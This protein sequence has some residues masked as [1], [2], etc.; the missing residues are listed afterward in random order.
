MFSLPAGLHYRV[1]AVADQRGISMAAYI[2]ETLE[3]ALDIAAVHKIP[4]ARAAYTAVEERPKEVADMKRIVVS[5][6]NDLHERLRVMGASRGI[7]MA[8]FVRD[9]L[10]ER[11]TQARPKPRFGAFASGYTDTGRLA[12]EMLYEPRSWR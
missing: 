5:L 3:D 11:I 8:A 9:A 1:K 4:E 7:S 12:G 6:P 10:E 2:R